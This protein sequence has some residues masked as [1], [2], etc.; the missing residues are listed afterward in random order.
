LSTRDGERVSAKPEPFT[1]PVR[2]DLLVA[3]L[4][5]LEKRT[6]GG[7]L[8][9][10]A[11]DSGVIYRN[12]DWPSWKTD[13]E[14]LAEPGA[15]DDADLDTCCKLLTVIVR[16]DRFSEGSIDAHV[17]SGLAAR[18]VRRI[19]ELNATAVPDEKKPAKRRRKR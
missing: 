3:L 1:T 18:I 7:R 10:V 11:H 17:A 2:F 14:Y 5:E 12:F 8:I 19:A 15:L 9:V 16:Q 6:G 4:P 13:R